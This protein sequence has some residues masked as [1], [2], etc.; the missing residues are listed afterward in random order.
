MDYFIS[1]LFSLMS[2]E[3]KLEVKN[4]G[5]DRSNDIQIQQKEK[6]QN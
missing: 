1:Y 4:L 3:E 5:E 2:S 6:R